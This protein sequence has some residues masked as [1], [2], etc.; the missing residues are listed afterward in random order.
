[1]EYWNDGIRIKNEISSVRESQNNAVALLFVGLK[2]NCAC[3]AIVPQGGAKD[4]WRA[5]RFKYSN[6]GKMK[7]VLR[8]DNNG[9]RD[10]DSQGTGCVSEPE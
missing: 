6:N 8:K 4:G 10:D 1:M 9:K 7:N 3:Q 5:L 2:P